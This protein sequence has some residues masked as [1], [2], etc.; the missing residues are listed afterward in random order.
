MEN[1]IYSDELYHYG[2]KGMKWGQNIF[3]KI[4]TAK[5]NRTRKKNLE[6]ARA[7][8]V[9]KAKAA[10]K[11]QRLLEKDKLS[12]KKMTDD[13]IRQ[14]MDRLGLE[15]KLKEAQRE[16]RSYS[17]AKRFLDKFMDS[18]IDR[19]ADAAGDM[20][21]QTVKVYI[22]EGINSGIFKV[23]EGGEKKVNTNNKKK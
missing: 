18:A 21:A 17:K 1:N 9:E 5:Q 20:V 2:R 23:P 3:G 6:K 11:R 15:K 7:A 13:E 19:T 14:R 8:K 22:E 12:V 10:A 4:K 16:V